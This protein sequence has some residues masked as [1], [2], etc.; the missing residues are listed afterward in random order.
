MVRWTYFII[1]ETDPAGGVNYTITGTSQLLSVP[2]A[3]YAKTASSSSDAVK[4]TGDQSIA[5]TKNFT[6][7]V[8]VGTPVNTTD[9][10]NKAYV[11][12]YWKD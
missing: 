1:T 6:G 5:G 2:Y 11:D 12:D 9:A 7:T 3:F 4:L 10:T 8:T